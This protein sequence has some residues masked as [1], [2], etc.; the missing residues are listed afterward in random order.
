MKPAEDK[1]FQD[2]DLDIRSLLSLSERFFHFEG[3]CPVRLTD[4]SLLMAVAHSFSDFRVLDSIKKT[5]KKNIHLLRTDPGMIDSLRKQVLSQLQPERPLRT[6]DRPDNDAQKAEAEDLKIYTGDMA[7]TVRLVNRI[8]IQAFR[9][10]ATD[11]HIQKTG[12]RPSVRFR[13][14]GMLYESQSFASEDYDRVITRLKVISRLDIAESRA[15]QSGRATVKIDKD[16]ISLRVSTLPSRAGEKI[17]VRFLYGIQD[18]LPVESLGL[19]EPQVIKLLKHL[20]ITSGIFIIGGPTGTG[21]TTTLYSII[22]R[23]ND[24]KKNIITLEDP[25]EVELGR[26]VTQVQ[27]NSSRGITFEDGIRTILRH[28]PDIILIGEIRDRESAQAAFEAALT[29]HLVFST[30]HMPTVFDIVERLYQLGIDPLTIESTLIGVATQ[31]LLRKI[32]PDCSEKIKPPPGSAQFFSEYGLKIAHDYSCSGCASCGSRGY[33]GRTGIFD[34]YFSDE[35]EL[36]SYFRGRDKR[37]LRRG[38]KYR[39]LIRE[40]LESIHQGITNSGEVMRSLWS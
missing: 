38:D 5:L 3:L 31:R 23:L 18:I 28:D 27:V 25:A 37:A 30:V 17:S 13:I 24:G 10:R 12:G 26:G 19:H 8:I 16:T 2:T 7:E 22:N 35:E 9:E 39:G 21:K 40:A 20:N 36:L 6:E 11:I 4:D 34:V 14:D 15:P 33:K 1:A 29:G 32:C